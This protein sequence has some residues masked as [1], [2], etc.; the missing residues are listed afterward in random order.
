MLKEVPRRNTMLIR[1]D[2]NRRTVRVGAGNHQNT[3]ALQPVV[4]RKDIC[5]Q[6]RTG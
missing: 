4:E 2:G 3:V 5:R 1:F 6:E